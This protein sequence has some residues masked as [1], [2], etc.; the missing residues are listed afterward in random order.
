MDRLFLLLPK[1]DKVWK[2]EI[3]SIKR[4]FFVSFLQ[5]VVF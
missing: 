5:K 4:L 2:S 3:F 1:M